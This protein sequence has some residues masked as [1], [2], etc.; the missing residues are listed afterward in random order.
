MCLT[1]VLD[2][3]FGFVVNKGVSRRVLDAVIPELNAGMEASY[4][5]GANYWAVTGIDVWPANNED[6]AHVFLKLQFSGEALV[7]ITNKVANRS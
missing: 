2:L 1:D 3:D 6:R 7:E 4:N 5:A